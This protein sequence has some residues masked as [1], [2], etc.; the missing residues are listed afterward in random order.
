MNL[1][2]EINAFYDSTALCNLRLMNKRFVTKT[3]NPADHRQ[4][5]LSVN[6]EAVRLYRVYR[7]QED[8]V[9]KLISKQFLAEDVEKFCR[10]LR[11]FTDINFKDCE[12]EAIL[13]E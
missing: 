13:G 12:W 11:I 3:P 4:N 9:S 8:L 7:A 10:M 5:L 1:H 2:D 6:E